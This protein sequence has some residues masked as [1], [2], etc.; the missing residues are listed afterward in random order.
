MQQRDRFKRS[1]ARVD[2]LD[3]SEISWLGAVARIQ[4]E[5]TTTQTLPRMCLFGINS[6]CTARSWC[7]QIAQTH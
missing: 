1:L 3:I 6:P 7:W 4:A 2:V 5:S